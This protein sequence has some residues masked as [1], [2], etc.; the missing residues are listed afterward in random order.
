MTR[1]EKGTARLGGRESRREGRYIIEVEEDILLRRR[2]G[3]ESRRGRGKK[4]EMMV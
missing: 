2:R 1:S 4:Q 3:Y